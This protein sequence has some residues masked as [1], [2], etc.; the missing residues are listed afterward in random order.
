MVESS[1]IQGNSDAVIIEG[2]IWAAIWH[3]SW[4]IVIDFGAIA[5]ASLFDAWIAGRIGASAQAAIGVGAQIMYLLIIL[6]NALPM[7]ASALVS[8]FWG[9]G[10]KKEALEAA[11]HSI[12]FAF[13]FGV[14]AVIFGLVI[15]RPL[16]KFLGATPE[17]ED[18][19]WQFLQFELLSN[20]PFCVLWITKAIFR[21]KG[22][23]RLP[24]AITFFT[25]GI[26][27]VTEIVLCI[28]PFKLG[29]AGIGIAWL[30]AGSLSACLILHLLKES[31][32]GDCLN[33]LYLRP[34]YWSFK[35]LKRLMNIGIPACI[36][37][38]VWVVC[39]FAI[40]LI[41][42]RT[43]DPTAGQ[44]A[45]AVGL[46]VEELLASFPLYALARAAG[47]LV[48]QNLGAKRPDRAS[49]AGWQIASA[50]ACWCL[51]VAIS[52]FLFGNQIAAL[53]SNS[54][55]VIADSVRYLQ[56]IGLSLPFQAF[57]IT[58]FGAMQGAGYTRWPMVAEVTCLLF[59]R[60]PLCWYLSIGLHLGSLGTWTGMALS[61][62]LVGI[63]ASWQFK[64]GT[65][66][67]Q[68]V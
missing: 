42:A 4:P 38:V 37:D 12:I 29:M 21:A 19:A 1:D 28:Y 40:L 57:A 34:Q 65:W 39:N 46:R 51:V 63:L 11:R 27:L 68:T 60:L 15:C 16:L 50:S 26:T 45:W 6:T 14:A 35:W 23:A 24:M 43:H 25:C 67:S 49:L 9:A 59:I 56:I 31:D 48:G 10:D 41:L 61:V 20:L 22:N 53:M 36:Q 3:M 55:D 30:V 52:M 62:V 54:T 18:L 13:F 8:R 7:G 5:L 2:S 33:F 32:M 66:K 64:K 17:T 44:A 47:T 58:L